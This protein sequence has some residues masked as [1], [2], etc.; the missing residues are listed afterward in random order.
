MMNRNYWHSNLIRLRAVEPE[1][2]DAFF[3]FNLDSEMARNLDF[4]WPPSS[5]AEVREWAEKQSLKKLENG[6]FFW[7]IEDADGVAVGQIST[8]GCDAHNGTFEYGV[9]VANEHQR[10]G[11]AR[12]AIQIVLR[13]FF[14]ELRYQ[15]VTVCIHAD[16][17]ESIALHEGL[18]FVHEG[19]LRRMFFTRGAYWD[20]FY[21]GL[22]KEE[23]VA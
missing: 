8:H 19:T 15:K 13:Y 12:A 3:G 6:A 21:Y 23:W 11:Y 4:V 22:T 20:L 7:V 10:K 5:M 18:G 9:S 16:N 2:A 14:E 17:P 1:D